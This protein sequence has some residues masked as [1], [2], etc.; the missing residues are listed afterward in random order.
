[1]KV[2]IVIAV[3]SIIVFAGYKMWKFS[4]PSKANTGGSAAGSNNE[5]EVVTD[6]K[7]D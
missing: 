7:N 6:I 3:I 2:V 4:Q 1:M 5:D